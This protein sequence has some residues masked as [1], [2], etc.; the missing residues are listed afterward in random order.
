MQ[1]LVASCG[2]VADCNQLASLSPCKRERETMVAARLLKK[3]KRP[4]LES[5]FVGLFWAII[6]GG[7]RR[8][9]RAPSVEHGS[10]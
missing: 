2:A 10:L 3:R 8:G 7:Q 1:D 4:Y 5:E 6:Q 9:G